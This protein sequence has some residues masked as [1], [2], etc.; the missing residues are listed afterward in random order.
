[1]TDL[2]RQRT[3][4]TRADVA[5]HAGISQ[6]TVAYVLN[7]TPGVKIRPET[8]TKVLES[9][10]L[11]GYTPSFSA[12]SMKRGRTE[13]IGILTPAPSSQF[14]PYYAQMLHGLHEAAADTDFH[15][16]S[17]TSDRAEKYRRCLRQNY[18][19]GV[20]VMQSDENWQPLQDVIAQ[21]LPLVTLNVRHS[22]PV[23]QISMDYEAAMECAVQTLIDEGSRRLLFVHGVWNNQ[24]IQRYRSAFSEAATEC[25]ND[26]FRFDT[27]E[28]ERYR[29]LPDQVAM[30]LNEG[31][32]GLIVDGY[33]LGRE[34]SQQAENS[35]SDSAVRIS[36]FSET[37]NAISLGKHTHL[38]Q[39]Q[40][41]E[42]GRQAWHALERQL[43]GE[44][45]DLNPVNIP[46]FDTTPKSVY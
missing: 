32:D 8:R 3:R 22:F 13:L 30:L 37:A 20:L 10:K 31:W 2:G 15:F 19:D 27:L 14:H 24:P 18:L 33:E 45:P 43:K 44:S 6:T 17:L 7:E 1:M 46:F 41:Y 16:L 39:A 28:I 12:R 29:L 35:A 25:G 38:L 26:A 9:A 36:I 42:V 34:I 40:P 23:P 5:R 4:V 21:H 11:L